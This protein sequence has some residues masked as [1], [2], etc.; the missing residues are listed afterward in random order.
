MDKKVR[1]L[2]RFDNL[3]NAF[4]FL[5]KGLEKKSPDSYQEAGIIKGFEL[6]FELCWKTLKDF[7]EDKGTIAAYPRDVIKE[8][9]SVQLIRDGSLWLEMLEKRNH[10]AHI[11]NETQAQ[12]AIQLIKTRYLAGLEQVYLELKKLCSA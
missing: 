8:A 9:F 1:W 11:Y 12:H 7:L 6:T 4:L 2:Q 10:L 5:Q 3:E